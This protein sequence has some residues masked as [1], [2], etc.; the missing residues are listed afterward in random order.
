[1]V[2]SL[3]QCAPWDG[4]CCW[5]HRYRRDAE[6]PEHEQHGQPRRQQ[7]GGHRCKEEMSMQLTL[8]MQGTTNEFPPGQGR[9]S[10]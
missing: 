6:P 4:N 2:L 1:M 7:P 10:S 8:G 5:D 3:G 9:T